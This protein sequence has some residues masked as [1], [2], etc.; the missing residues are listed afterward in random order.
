MYTYNN[1]NLVIVLL[2]KKAHKTRRQLQ[3]EKTAVAERLVQ[4]ANELVNPLETLPKLQ[5]YTSKDG[6]VVE[7]SCGPVKT[8][9]A[10]TMPLIFDLM[11]RNMK[12]MYEQS[13]WGWNET[14]K[15]AELTDDNAWYLIATSEGKMSGF[16]H[17]RFDLDNGM[18]V[19]YW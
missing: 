18:E 7:M 5:N 14:S 13:K 17:F 11:E 2:Q 19:L 8:V 10:D 15:H 9:P 4:K 6:A 16:S 12:T 3:A 1:R